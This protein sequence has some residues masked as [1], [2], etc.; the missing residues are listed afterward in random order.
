MRR[1]ARLEADAK[2]IRRE[3][4]RDIDLYEITSE[5]LVPWI[6]ERREEARLAKERRA[7]TRAPAG[8]SSAAIAGPR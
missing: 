3:R 5:F 4:R 2:L 7:R 8:A 1:S 6:S